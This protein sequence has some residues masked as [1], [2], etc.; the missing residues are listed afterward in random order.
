MFEKGK[1]VLIDPPTGWMYG[2]PK[3][4]IVGDDVKQFLLDNG[5][6]A[7]DVEWASKHCRFIGLSKRD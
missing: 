6:P 3:D 1:K 2:F 5:Y 4:F 7:E